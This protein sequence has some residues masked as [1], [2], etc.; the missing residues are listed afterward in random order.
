M[1][2]RALACPGV[3]VLMSGVMAQAIACNDVQGVSVAPCVPA[4]AGT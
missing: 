4:L 1:L 3:F 2:R